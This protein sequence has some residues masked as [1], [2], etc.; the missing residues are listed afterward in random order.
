MQIH[1][2]ITDVDAQLCSSY[3]R[4]LKYIL[5]DGLQVRN[6]WDVTDVV[7]HRLYHHITGREHKLMGAHLRNHSGLKSVI[8]TKVQ[9]FVLN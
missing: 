3:L 2:V 7:G 4:V 6:V 5:S 8:C 1:K 9:Q